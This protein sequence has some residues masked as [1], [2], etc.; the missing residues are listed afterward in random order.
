MGYFDKDAVSNSRLGLVDSLINGKSIIKAKAETLLFGNMIHESI[1]EPEVYA[2]KMA[3]NEP[4]YKFLRFKVKSMHDSAMKNILLV[5]YLNH[6]NIKK[7]FEGDFIDP[8]SGEP[9]KFKADIIIPSI[10]ADLKTTDALTRQ[11]FEARIFEYGYDRQAAFYLDGL[12]INGTQIDKFTFIA[13]AKRA[14]HP[15]FTY[16]FDRD[17]E[18]IQNGRKKYQHLIGEYLKIKDKYNFQELMKAA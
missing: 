13:I 10:G 7:E 3:N 17:S 5:H 8:I 11:D 4:G 16:T 2:W 6:P 12:T 15:T 9:C 1:L 14:P 18:V